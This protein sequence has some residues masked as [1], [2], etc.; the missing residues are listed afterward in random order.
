MDCGLAREQLNV[1]R[2]DSGDRED[3][4]LEEAF[5]H[6]DGCPA[7][8]EVVE[9]RR[10]FDRHFGRALR[11]VPVPSGLKERLLAAVE[12]S[13]QPAPE[14]DRPSRRSRRK[15]LL[16]TISA[17]ALLIAAGAAWLFTHDVPVP[18]AM[19]EVR[20]WWSS[21][22]ERGEPVAELPAFDG[23]F[24]PTIQDGRWASLIKA[25][26]LGADI[27]GD[28]RHDAAVY[29]F[30]TGFLVVMAPGR[31]SDA[32]DAGSAVSAPPSYRPAPNVAWTLD[33]QV[34]LCYVEQGGQ[35]GLKEVLNRVYD[36][37]A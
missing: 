37:H 32:P 29:Q 4:A 2:P 3:P 18:L 23:S 8:A 6:V 19:E 21:R 9:F 20:A 34:Y 12:L 36:A 7:C 10:E 27:D 25:Q 35:R 1:A 28:G 33:G 15:V 17:A 13:V 26:P 5:A 14:E 31:V 11:D 30:T 24:D 22:L 16:A